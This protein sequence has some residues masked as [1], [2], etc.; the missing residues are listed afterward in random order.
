[1][2]APLAGPP[3]LSTTSAASTQSGSNAPL[4]RHG[5]V[6]TMEF[7]LTTLHI[8]IPPA[9]HLGAMMKSM[10]RPAIWQR[11]LDASKRQA[12]LAVKLYNDPSDALALEGF[13]I[14][15]HLAWLYYFQA[16]FQKEKERLGFEMSGSKR[17]AM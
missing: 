4:P 8:T 15:M 17:S 2:S 12:L 13:V 1:M 16:K 7:I 9:F 14:H 6:R 10:A 3:A 11:T 5:F